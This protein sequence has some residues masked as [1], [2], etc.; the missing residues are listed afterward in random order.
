MGS[1]VEK[2]GR[3]LSDKP[4]TGNGGTQLSTFSAKGETQY[5]DGAPHRPVRGD[6]SRR[7]LTMAPAC[8][9]YHICMQE[10]DDFLAAERLW[11]FRGRRQF[12]WQ[13]DDEYL[14]EE[15]KD[16]IHGWKRFRHRSKCL[17]ATKQRG[18]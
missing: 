1:D 7:S 2:V 14:I 18:R 8:C 9:S 3:L 5:A 4:P 12:S 16:L 13:D 6:C 17:A 10:D 15:K 11:F